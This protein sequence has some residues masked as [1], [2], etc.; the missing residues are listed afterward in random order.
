MSKK[1][2]E[3]EDYKKYV[4]GVINSHNERIARPV[5]E[6]RRLIAELRRPI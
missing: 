2:E 5:E 3:L 4:E 6:M 1:N